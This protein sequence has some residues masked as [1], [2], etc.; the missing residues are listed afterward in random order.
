MPS[1]KR[2]DTVKWPTFQ[3]VGDDDVP[4]DITNMKIDMW[5]RRGSL[6]GVITAK[7]STNDLTIEITESD[8]GKFKLKETAISWDA[9]TYYCDLQ[10]IQGEKQTTP[11]TL[12]MTVL[13]DGTHQSY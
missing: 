9:G 3:L 4:L 12:I 6:R 2:G 8:E 13:E 10:T 1:V 5:W 11:M 7:F